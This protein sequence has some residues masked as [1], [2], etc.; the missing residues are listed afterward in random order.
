MFWHAFVALK[1]NIHD[2][3]FTAGRFRLL[4]FSISGG[5]RSTD[6]P[7]TV[8]F[9][10]FIT[11]WIFFFL[12]SRRDTNR[13]W[14]IGHNINSYNNDIV[15]S[16]DVWRWRFTSAAMI[17][18]QSLTYRSLAVISRCLANIIRYVLLTRVRCTSAVDDDD[19]LLAVIFVCGPRNRAQRTTLHDKTLSKQYVT[20]TAVCPCR[21]VQT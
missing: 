1:E 12:L 4:C 19:V 6:N 3:L 15:S 7:I 10:K 20:D 16:S 2:I 9:Y 18:V 8:L 11:F 13:Y 17:A 5:T 21:Y 14:F